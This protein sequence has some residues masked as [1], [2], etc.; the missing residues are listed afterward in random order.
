MNLI[1]VCH[2]FILRRETAEKNNLS[3]FLLAPIGDR[4][5]FRFKDDRAEN[6]PPAVWYDGCVWGQQSKIEHQ[7]N[8]SMFLLPAEND[9]VTRWKRYEF[10]QPDRVAESLP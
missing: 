5:G 9:V 4:C 6:E 1:I 3:C 10:L 7:K 2:V 8:D